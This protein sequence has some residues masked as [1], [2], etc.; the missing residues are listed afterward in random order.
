MNHETIISTTRTMS[1]FGEM[2]SDLTESFTTILLRVF[3]YN[4]ESGS[5]IRC[6]SHHGKG[7]P[8]IPNGEIVPGCSSYNADGK[9]GSLL[10]ASSNWNGW[11]CCGESDSS[12]SA[13]PTNE[14]ILGL[15][16][17]P[18]WVSPIDEHRCFLYQALFEI[19]IFGFK[20]ELILRGKF[21]RI[22]S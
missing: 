18:I 16:H 7:R 6:W 11:Q 12:C 21:E 13:R 10:D 14:L 8:G 22:H 2:R 9:E 15:V 17:L 5:T 19:Y 3:C 4:D 1:F 20:T